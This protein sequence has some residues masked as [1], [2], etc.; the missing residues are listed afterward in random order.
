MHIKKPDDIRTRNDLV[1]FLRQLSAS[2]VNDPASWENNDLQSFL[3]ALAAWVA[4]MDGYYLNRNQP[5]PET[6]EWKTLAEIL[7]AARHYE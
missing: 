7:L 3:E 5:I 4:D 2:Y 1:N 6:P